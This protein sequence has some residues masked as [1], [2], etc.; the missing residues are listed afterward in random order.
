M[1]TIAGLF[2]DGRN[3][4]RSNYAPRTL[5]SSKSRI[6]SL[7][8]GSHYGVTAT[9]RQKKL[10]RLWIES[11]AAYPGTYAALGSGMIGNYIEN[12]QVNTGVDWRETKAAAETIQRRCTGC[13]NDPSRV[14]PL[15]LADERG[16]SFWMPSLDD[17]R[18]N[19]SRHIVWN[20]SHPERSMMLL[21][22]LA[23]SAGGWEYCRDPKAKQPANVFADTRDPGYEKLLALCIAGKKFLEADKR[24]DTAGFEPRVDWVR[25]MKRYGIL[26]ASKGRADLLD[27]YAVEREY[28]KSLWYQPQRIGIS[29]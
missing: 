1:L 25:E 8:D 2:S 26:P 14:L 15:S 5:G 27:V 29:N 28:W 11:G 24:F 6:L 10:L 3:Q 16:V 20:L 17:P 21:A 9:A 13:H 23:K 4:P 12:N 7:L 22:P 19:T 18:L